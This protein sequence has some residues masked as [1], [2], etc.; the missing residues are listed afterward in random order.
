MVVGCCVGVVDEG[1]KV[2]LPTREF[3]LFDLVKDWIGVAV[4][5]LM[6]WVIGKRAAIKFENS[7]HEAEKEKRIKS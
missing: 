6:I 7:S 1:I 2:L 5:M 3:D 4:A